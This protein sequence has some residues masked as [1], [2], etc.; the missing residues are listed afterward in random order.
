MLFG[1]MSDATPSNN[2]QQIDEE[3][4]RLRLFIAS[5]T[6]YAIY[7]L[8]P[9]G[10][11]ASWNAGAERFKG[12][13]A[14]EIIGRHFSQFYTEED[15]ATRLPWRALEI[16]ATEGKFEAEGWRVRKDGTRFWASVVID[17][18]DDRTVH[19]EQAFS[20]NGGA[21][22]EVNWIAVDRRR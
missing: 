1:W 2:P 9:E 5:V 6:D 11:V 17:V 14:G 12:Y 21:D 15:R 10:N 3:S 4:E 16:A 8:T 18:V 13:K 20:A 22:W 19:F 7:M